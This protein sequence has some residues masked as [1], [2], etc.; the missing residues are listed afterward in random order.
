MSYPGL[1]PAGINHPDTRC[2][3]A[4]ED[5]GISGLLAE[6]DRDRADERLI[7]LL[8]D[9]YQPVRLDRL[10]LTKPLTN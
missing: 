1:I 9:S 10:N 3:L 5:R 8:S 7:A 6:A 2:G 4:V